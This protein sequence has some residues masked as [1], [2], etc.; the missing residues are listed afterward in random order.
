MAVQGTG[1]L[2]AFGMVLLTVVCVVGSACAQVRPVPGATEQGTAPGGARATG[3]YLVTLASGSDSGV[4]REL[5]GKFHVRDVKELG[6]S[7][8]LVDIVDD[9]G[10]A[11]IED[12]LRKD[13][14]VKAVQ[15]NYLYHTNGLPK[16]R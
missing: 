12:A 10:P 8:F 9:P 16:A 6:N 5:L 15:P 3:Q 14:R 11:A 4:V 7:V 1:T 13:A 2:R